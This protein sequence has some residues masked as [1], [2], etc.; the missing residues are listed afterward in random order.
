[1]LLLHKTCMASFAACRLVPIAK[2][3]RMPTEASAVNQRA[4]AV[5]S[6]PRDERAVSAKN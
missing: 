6:M 2:M 4:K 3:K 5:G 1:M